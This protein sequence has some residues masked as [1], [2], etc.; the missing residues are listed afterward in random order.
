MVKIKIFLTSRETRFTFFL[1]EGAIHI[2]AYASWMHCSVCVCPI[3]FVLLPFFMLMISATC[4]T[5][6]DEDTVHCTVTF[7]LISEKEK[8][9]TLEFVLYACICVQVCARHVHTSQWSRW[10]SQKKRSIAA[11]ASKHIFLEPW[12]TLEKWSL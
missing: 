11:L 7:F 8:N 1:M 2:C 4:T 12:A 3:I 5:W 9:A 10:W 6:I